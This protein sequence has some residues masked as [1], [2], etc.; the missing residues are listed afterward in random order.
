MNTLYVLYCQY[1]LLSFFKI[2]FELNKMKGWEI[3]KIGSDAWHD[4]AR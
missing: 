4:A 3:K 2:N 1:C